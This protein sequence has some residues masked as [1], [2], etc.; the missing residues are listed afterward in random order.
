VHTCAAR[1]AL[2]AQYPRLL[3]YLPLVQPVM[4]GL[5]PPPADPTKISDAIAGLNA[6]DTAIEGGN[7]DGQPELFCG[8][9]ILSSGDAVAAEVL[10]GK[11]FSNGSAAGLTGTM[12]NNGAVNITPSTSAQTIAAGYHNGSG[13]VAGDADLISTNIRF[14][15]NIFGVSGSVIQAT[16][17]AGLG[18][19]LAG[20]TFSN[21]GGSGMGTMPNNGAVTLTP[22]TSNQSIAAGYHNGA[23]VC[24]GDADLVSGNIKAG[25]D[26]FGVSGDPDVVDTSSGDAV[27]S[28]IALG[29]KAWV[30]GAEVTGT[31]LPAPLLKTAQTTAYGTGSDGDLQK[32]LARSYTDNGDGTVTDE[33]TGLMWEKKSDDGSIHDKDNYYTWGM[34]S[35]PYTMNGTMVTTFLDQLNNRCKNDETISCSVDAD[36]SV[37]GGPCGF[38]GYRDWRMPNVIELQSI[39]SYEAF[40]PSVSSAFHTGC[41]P[42]CTVT[43]CSCTLSGHY[44]SSSTLTAGPGNAWAVIFN[45]GDVVNLS[46]LFGTYVR[47]VR[48][49]S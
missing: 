17:N 40:N 15:A 1:S 44:W 33:Q 48:G 21:I 47:A 9:G 4:S 10:S 26:L 39:V 37:P 42:A 36:C 24:E 30:D 35:P 45:D 2:A 3:D 23:G 32:G 25:V 16:G 8:P 12:P 41:V 11:T 46:K 28:D 7:N 29:K 19:V 5:T 31:K 43:I 14:G 13:S 20:K 34:S 49:G 38:A 18:D 6:D 22:T 27:A